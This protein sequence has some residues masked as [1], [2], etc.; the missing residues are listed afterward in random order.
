MTSAAE[1]KRAERERKREAGLIKVELWIPPQLAERVR[2]YV[3]R[4]VS[5]VTR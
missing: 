3:E 2:K 4:L 5:R 1:R